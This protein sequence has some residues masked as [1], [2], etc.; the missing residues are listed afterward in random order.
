MKYI[1]IISAHIDNIEKVNLL[2]AKLKYFQIN[3]IDTC[4][5]IHSK[6]FLDEIVK[7]T[8]FLL[9]D[10]NNDGVYLK[11]FIEHADVVHNSLYTISTYTNTANILIEN[12]VPEAYHSKAA[13]ILFKHGIDIAIS[14]NYEWC[15]YLEYDMPKHDLKN[16]IENKIQNLIKYNKKCFYYELDTMQY[17]RLSSLLFITKPENFKKSKIFKYD[18]YS[19]KNWIKYFGTAFFEIVVQLCINEVFDKSEV[20]TLLLSD[21]RIKMDFGYHSYDEVNIFSAFNADTSLSKFNLNLI[22]YKKSENKFGVILH[23]INLA[24]TKIIKNIEVFADKHLIINISEKELNTNVW[25]YEYLNID[26]EKHEELLLKYDIVI[27]S[28]VISNMFKFQTK[29][30]SNVYNHV[31]NAKFI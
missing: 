10:N 2:I 26:L 12:K 24:Q 31:I 17:K 19:I 18:F 4:V 14:N 20:E 22:P 7:Y 13:M 3:N 16:L 28:S 21:D 27:N 30:I 25:F 6:M 1:V 11:D 8:K 5:V 9:Y 15:V 29:Y 23:G